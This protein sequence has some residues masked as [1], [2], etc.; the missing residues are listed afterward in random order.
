MILKRF[1]T[2]NQRVAYKFALV[3]S[4]AILLFTSTYAGYR[5]SQ[6]YSTDS[7][8]IVSAQLF[9]KTAKTPIVVPGPHSNLLVDPLFYI[10]GHLP[11]NYKSF[12]L[13]NV[14]LVLITM[15]AWAILLI[16][17]FGRKYEILILLLLSSLILTSVTFSLS[18]GYTAIR[19]IQYPI[20]LLFVMIVSQLLGSKRKYT[21]LQLWSTAIGSVLFSITLAGDDFFIY[22]LFLPLLFVIIL[23]WVQSTKFTRNMVKALLLLGAVYL[24]AELMK[25]IL[26]AT[27]ILDFN[28]TFGVQN[29]I[30]PTRALG[31]SLTIALQQL[32][33]L[34]GANI[35][36][37]VI[38][39]HNLAI[40]VNFGL[41]LTG[42]VS[43]FMILFL[44]NR[45]FRAKV[46]IVDSNNY[47]FSVV[48]V[49]YFVTFWI[50]VLSGYVI[51]T[52]PNGH[53]I[54]VENTRCI[55]FMPLL[56]T[57][58]IIW[59]IK[60]YFSEARAFLA[61][62]CAVLIICM[63][64]GFSGVNTLYK[65]GVQMELAPSR[66]SID[67]IIDILRQN[68]VNTVL[69][70]YW[71]APVITFWS[72]N[73]FSLAAQPT[74]IPNSQQAKFIYNKGT[75]AALIIDRGGLNYAFW[76]CTDQHLL[77][78][79]GAPDKKFEVPG[80]TS[81]PVQIWLYSQK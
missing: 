65:S 28:F 45:S 29:T 35:F 48:A 40:F 36:G 42:M 11:Y 23:F 37:Q 19:N 69:A 25:A 38:Q 51:T 54:S 79:Y 56:G 17:L 64:V 52:L 15:I 9:N 74:C 55:S 5:A 67:Q 61:V 12:T 66:A 32:L 80:V 33:N 20:A 3:L 30:I 75:K 2:S 44:A 13:G 34:Q 81:N 21:R 7:N 46:G 53:I 76:N 50:Y 31:P 8:A 78:T 27:N 73:E 60:N 49:C 39:L 59:L 68:N 72:N 16:K 71:Y 62:L 57:V 77:Q 18:L 47:V 26:S 41:F 63:A 4:V 58:G 10:Q 24:G 1:S 6:A 22:G 14:S 70:D 43:L